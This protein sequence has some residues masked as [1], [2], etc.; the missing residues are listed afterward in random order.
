MQ[1]SPLFTDLYQLTM[2]Y[3]YWKLNM[4]EQKAA[5]HLL[6]RHAPFGGHIALSCGIGSLIEFLQ[7]WHFSPDD[8]L[9]LASLKNTVNDPLLSPAF[10]DYLS[11]LTFS[12][13][14]A[15]IPEGTIVF[16]NEP[17]LRIEGP[18]L[19]CQLLESALL[20]MI[21]FET[22]IATKAARVY[23]AANGD[24][25]IEFG[26][27]RAQGP[28][29]AL[30]ASRAAYIGGATATSNTLAGK[31]YNIPVRGTHAHSWVSAF[32]NEQAAFHAYAEVMPQQCILLVDTYDSKQG[33]LHA[34][35][36]GKHLR[37]HGAELLGIRLDSGNLAT[38]SII[39]RQ[40]LDEAGF[41]NTLILASNALD[42]YAITALKQAGAK[43]SMWGVGTNL[44]TAYDQAALDG[45][46]KLSALR[47]P[48]GKW[49]YKLKLSEQTIKI[50]NPGRHQ[51]RRYVHADGTI[52]DI[53]YDLTLGIS[54]TPAFFPFFP[55]SAEHEQ[56]LPLAISCTELL[57]PLFECGKLIAA[58]TSIH[59]IRARA[60]QATEHFHNKVRGYTIGLEKQLYLLKK[61]LINTYKQLI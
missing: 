31:K 55:T 7:H 50:S 37:T 53:I 20:N 10:L 17:L 41:H 52:S 23:Q 40:L 51:I 49:Q 12:C 28:N 29:G 9:Y 5:F 35:E 19:Q 25:I 13:S 27:R 59:D 22:L 3:G 8:L 32:E 54:A 2:A 58:P 47:H 4:H 14:I 33:I 16:A 46:Y 26:M 42:E 38:L 15:A 43:I 6:F 30:A 44:V 39:A 11:T 45:V 21:N 61:H 48:T 60:I 34:I 1:L 56:T 57:V 24:P 36:T 18:L